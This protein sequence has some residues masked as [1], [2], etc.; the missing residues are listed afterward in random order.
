MVRDIARFIQLPELEET[1]NSLFGTDKWK[2][3]L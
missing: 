1:F 2:D 3:I